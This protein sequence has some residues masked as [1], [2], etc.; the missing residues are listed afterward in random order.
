MGERGFQVQKQGATFLA[1]RAML[2][3]STVGPLQTA[4]RGC[5]S[6]HSPKPI[7]L[8]QYRAASKLSPLS[9]WLLPNWM[10][11]F[12][13][14]A[15]THSS[16]Q[17]AV[18]VFSQ[19]RETC[20]RESVLHL[21]GCPSQA[22]QLQQWPVLRALQGWKRPRPACSPQ[23]LVGGRLAISVNAS[24]LQAAWFWNFLFPMRTNKKTQR[25]KYELHIISHLH[26]LCCLVSTSSSQAQTA[27]VLAFWRPLGKR[28]VLQ[29]LRIVCLCAS[30]F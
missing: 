3:S 4:A 1:F 16:E 5:T 24:E 2:R 12:W 19:L 11:S 20:L 17:W 28:V 23:N 13:T 15:P 14:A 25:F 30:L 7:C 21:L 18:V 8:W 9:G 10:I 27:H 6:T 22:Q 26:L 29:G